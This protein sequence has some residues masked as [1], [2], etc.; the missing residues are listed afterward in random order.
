MKYFLTLMLLAVVT[1]AQEQNDSDTAYEESEWNIGS[2]WQTLSHTM[3]WDQ[4]R[5]RNSTMLEI[6]YGFSEGLFKFQ[7][8]MTSS[9]FTEGLTYFKGTWYT[10]KKAW[11]LGDLDS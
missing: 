4:R 6:E 5:D 1:T 10:M 2:Y 7:P 3:H 8:R 9:C 11:K